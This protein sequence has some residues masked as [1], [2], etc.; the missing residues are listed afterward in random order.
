[1]M[2]WKIETN[3]IVSY[4]KMSITFLSQDGHRFE[5]DKD[6]LM[7][8]SPMFDRFL[9]KENVI[10]FDIDYPSYVVKNIVEYIEKGNF[11]KPS[12]D[13][14]SYAEDIYKLGKEL[15]FVDWKKKFYT[16]MIIAPLLYCTCVIKWRC[17][18]ENLALISSAVI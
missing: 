4:N 10:T 3:F 14:M 15:E 2:N 16:M 9:Q 6:K 18:D 1:M 13:V 17:P 11:G 5:V 8:K 12:Q 7:A